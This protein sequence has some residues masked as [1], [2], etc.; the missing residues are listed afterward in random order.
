MAYEEGTM[1]GY[2]LTTSVPVLDNLP[3]RVPFVLTAEEEKETSSMVR[4]PATRKQDASRLLR[5]EHRWWLGAETTPYWTRSVVF[6]LDEVTPFLG[7]GGPRQSRVF[8]GRASNS[9]VRNTRIQEKSRGMRDR[10][11]VK[12]EAL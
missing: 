4:T 11:G 12:R 6:L 5:G 7:R 2:V 8:T 3:H 9:T 1:T 10:D